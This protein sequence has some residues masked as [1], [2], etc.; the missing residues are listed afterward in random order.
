MKG[1][2]WIDTENIHVYTKGNYNNECW[3]Y[4]R[5]DQPIF[6]LKLARYSDVSGH[7]SY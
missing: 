7:L 2:V 6:I 4:F 5:D 1:I 3:I